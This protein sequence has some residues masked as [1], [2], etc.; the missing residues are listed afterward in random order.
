M[1][2]RVGGARGIGGPEVRRAIFIW[3][4]LL[5]AAPA[6]FSATIMFSGALAAD[7]SVQTFLYSVQN[8]SLVTIDT[9]VRHWRICSHPQR[10]R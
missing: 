8:T 2:L 10:L 9:V 4:A 3:V 6:G 7:D 5:V 1:W